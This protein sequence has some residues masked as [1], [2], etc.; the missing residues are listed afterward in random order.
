[1]ALMLNKR[2]LSPLM[3]TD[4]VPAKGE[5]YATVKVVAGV[6]YVVLDGPGSIMT[7][8][9]ATTKLND[10][11]RVIVRV[12]NHRATV[13]GNLSSKAVDERTADGIDKA[14]QERAERLKEAIEDVQGDV[15]A[16]ADLIA[17]VN[18]KA[19]NA[20]SAAANAQ[21]T[22]DDVAGEMQPIKDGIDD[23]R[24]VADGAAAAISEA[25]KTVL[26]G[27]KDSYEVE[28][29]AATLGGTLG[30]LVE[31]SA[32]GIASKVSREEWQRNSDEV[33]GA[34]GELS[35]KLYGATAELDAL[36]AAEAE[37]QAG[38]EEARESLAAAR[39]V[40]DDLEAAGDA[41][42][43][44]LAAARATVASGEASVAQ[45]GRNLQEAR[46]AV[47]AARG[48]I[49]SLLAMIRG[50]GDRI[51]NAESSFEQ[52][53]TDITLQFQQKVAEVAAMTGG[54]D[55]AWKMLLTYFAFTIDGLKIGKA[56]SPFS[57]MITNDDI[58]FLEGSTAVSHIGNR[59]MFITRAEIVQQLAI[60]GWKLDQRPN[61]NLAI[62]YRGE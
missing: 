57:T 48:D 26:A 58:S 42:E 17:D 32:G 6:P 55:D 51:T 56:G 29:E 12:A 44:Q 24:K 28:T 41:T 43:E 10:G 46:E 31:A 52:T 38:L 61:G 22:A 11:D 40:L 9:T 53:A 19:D 35:G 7:P 27:L 15:N 3:G 21:K 33:N 60:G 34:L 23:A 8:C 45:A 4:P 18:T 1:M 14:A 2:V 54:M 37:A 50:L 49:E 30:A 20:A 36:K 47:E 5:Q 25:T 59:S 16:A 13:T 62:R 39:K